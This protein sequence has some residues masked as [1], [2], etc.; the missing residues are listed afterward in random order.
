MICG[1][2]RNLWRNLA[3]GLG[4]ERKR[5]ARAGS[6]GAGG[7]FDQGDFWVR[8]A[9]ELVDQGVDLAVRVLD[10]VLRDGPSRVNDS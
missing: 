6:V 9:V 4:E 1:P 3:V 10:L 5:G 2:L 8:E 7:V